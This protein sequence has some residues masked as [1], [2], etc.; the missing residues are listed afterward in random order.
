MVK[1]KPIENQMAGYRLLS[2]VDAF[3][4]VQQEMMHLIMISKSIDNLTEEKQKIQKVKSEVE[5]QRMLH[6][7]V[8]C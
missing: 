8:G 6:V 1:R 7:D 4:P 5:K 3:M 2:N